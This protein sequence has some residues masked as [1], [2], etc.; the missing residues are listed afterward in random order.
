VQLGDFGRENLIVTP[1]CNFGAELTEVIVRFSPIVAK[2]AI[3]TI[4][5]APKRAPRPAIDRCLARSP[6]IGADAAHAGSTMRAISSP[7]RGKAWLITRII[8]IIHGL[9]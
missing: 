7:M 9:G 1:N 3:G 4:Y 2:A 8:L 5:P 6:R